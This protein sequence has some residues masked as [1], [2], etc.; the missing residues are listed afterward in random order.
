M[1]ERRMKEGKLKKEEEGI[2]IKD[3]KRKV[4][5]GER[6]KGRTAREGD[7]VEGGRE[8]GSF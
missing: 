5:V 1:R 2:K 8:K 6:K 7:R 3:R 4:G